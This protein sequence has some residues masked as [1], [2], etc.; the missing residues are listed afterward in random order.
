M[1]PDYISQAEECYQNMLRILAYNDWKDEGVQKGVKVAKRQQEN[2]SIAMFKGEK[3][4]P[5]NPK[6]LSEV[7]AKE[8]TTQLLNKWD[9]TFEYYDRINV[10]AWII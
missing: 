5:G 4:V 10:G 7:F 8:A 9:S 6:E 1:A 2:S 3:I